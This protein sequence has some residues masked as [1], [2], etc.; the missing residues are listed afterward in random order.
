MKTDEGRHIAPGFVVIESVERV[1]G[2]D[3][4]LAGGTSVQVDLEGVL[5]AGARCGKGNEIAIM[6]FEEGRPGIGVELIETVD[7]GEPALIGEEDVDERLDVVGVWIGNPG[8]HG[9]GVENS[10]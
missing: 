1:T 4:G 7:G 3:A 10:S 5:L 6:G 2:G 8:A 9:L